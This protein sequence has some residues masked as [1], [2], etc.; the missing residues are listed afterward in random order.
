VNVSGQKPSDPKNNQ[1]VSRGRGGLELMWVPAHTGIE[2]NKSANKAAK[3]ALHEEPAP[4][5]R[6]TE[7]YWFKWT[8]E[9]AKKCMVG[10]R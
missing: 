6:V 4:E 9:D 1:P 2:G 3:E 5:T 7:S 8:K 10:I